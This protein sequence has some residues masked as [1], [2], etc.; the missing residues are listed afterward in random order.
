MEQTTYAGATIRTVRIARNGM[1]LFPS[2]TIHDGWLVI[3]AFPQN[4]KSHLWRLRHRT[5]S[6]KAPAIATQAIQAGMQQGNA[7]TRLAAVTVID[8]RRSLNLVLPW[9]PLGSLMSA[10]P[11]LYAASR[12]AFDVGAIP[13]TKAVTSKLSP[14]VTVLFD[15][16]DAW[17]WES[18]A[19]LEI[20]SG[21]EL[22]ILCLVPNLLELPF[23]ELRLP[24]APSGR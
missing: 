5:A 24:P 6:W 11:Y 7:R 3:G 18:H 14:N 16:G 20:P 17:R 4:V 9:A 13:H 8:P 12:P 22:G 21:V 2:Y 10:S 19:T 1:C 23:G 15:D